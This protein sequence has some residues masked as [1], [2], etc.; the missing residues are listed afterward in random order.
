M[1]SLSQF[2]LNR[3]AF[4]HQV[5]FNARHG[6]GKEQTSRVGGALTILVYGFIMAYMVIKA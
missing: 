1:M 3:D 2:L 4:G 6:N 5:S